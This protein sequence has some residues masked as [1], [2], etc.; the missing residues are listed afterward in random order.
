MGTLLATE[1]RIPEIF[2]EF[3]GMLKPGTYFTSANRMDGAVAAHH[4]EPACGPA[5]VLRCLP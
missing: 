3:T 2:Q 5:I 4:F 1:I